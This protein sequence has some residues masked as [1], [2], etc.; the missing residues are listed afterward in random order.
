[1]ERT[2]G[3]ALKHNLW[4]TFVFLSLIELFYMILFIAPT[5]KCY[6]NCKLASLVELCQLWLLMFFLHVC[7]IQFN[8]RG[9]DSV[10]KKTDYLTEDFLWLAMVCSSGRDSELSIEISSQALIGHYKNILHS[11]LGSLVAA[12]YMYWKWP[13]LL[14]REKKKKRTPNLYTHTQSTPR[15]PQKSQQNPPFFGI[16]HFIKIQVFLPYYAFQESL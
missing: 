8:N 2:S 13:W 10:L 1:M 16:Q 9:A 4:K 6:S 11:R 15:T 5:K 3:V 7:K 12:T 14:L